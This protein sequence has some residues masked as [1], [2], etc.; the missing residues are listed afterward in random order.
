M[1]EAQEDMHSA[2]KSVN[3]VFV[4]NLKNL[5]GVKTKEEIELR[6]KRLELRQEKFWQ[7]VEIERKKN[8]FNLLKTLKRRAFW[9]GFFSVFFDSNY[10]FRFKVTVIRNTTARPCGRAVFF[11]ILDINISQFCIRLNKTLSG[12]YLRTHEHIKDL[13]C[14]LGIIYGYLLKYTSS[15]IHCSFP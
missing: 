8:R 12:T 14:I 10:P 7:C 6:M 11:T 13:I 9:N 4:E 2:F 3:A 5:R 1:K 15:G